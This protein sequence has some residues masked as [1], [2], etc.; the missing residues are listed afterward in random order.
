MCFEKSL[1]TLLIVSYPRQDLQSEI[2]VLEGSIIA[3]QDNSSNLM[4]AA[5]SQAD[6][7][8]INDEVDGMVRRY[9]KLKGIVTEKYMQLEAGNQEVVKFQVKIC[10]ISFDMVILI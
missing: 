8:Q 10:I 5:P 3:V 9:Q 4:T 2:D 1:K 7:T 6:T